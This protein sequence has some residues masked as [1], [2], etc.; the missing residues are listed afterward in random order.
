MLIYFLKNK[1][2]FC[3]VNTVKKEEQHNGNDDND[4]ANNNDVYGNQINKLI[5][6]AYHII[7]QVSTCFLFKQY[8]IDSPYHYSYGRSSS[9]DLE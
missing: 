7:I 6:H 5:Q 2:Y 4:G 8:F 9:N 1:K 3:S